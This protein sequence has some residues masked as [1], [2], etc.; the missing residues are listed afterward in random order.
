MDPEER[1]YWFPA[2][3]YGWGWGLPNCWQG[4]VVFSV[5][6]LLLLAGTVLLKSHQDYFVAYAVFLAIVLMIVCVIKGE[7]PCWRWGGK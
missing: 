3:R 2:K 6:F 7:K 1:K 4:W 5:W